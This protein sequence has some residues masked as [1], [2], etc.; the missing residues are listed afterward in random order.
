MLRRKYIR[1][2]ASAGVLAIAGCASD[3]DDSTDEQ[4]TTTPTP[5]DTPT[6]EREVLV[7]E[8]LYYRERYPFDL[9]AG[10][11][12]VVSVDVERGGPVIV[13]VADAEAGE[14]LFSDRVET[15]ET[16]EVDIQST[17]THYVTFQNVSETTIEITLVEATG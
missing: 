11:R 15:E 17:G 2:V 9:Q 10:Q 8:T 1:A 7:D 4:A 14:S 16:F 5:T 3:D 13:D 12:L 6:P